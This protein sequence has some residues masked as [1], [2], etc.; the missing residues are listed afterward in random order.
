MNKYPRWL[1]LV[2]IAA[3]IGA[4]YLIWS[5]YAGSPAPKAPAAGEV[6][7]EPAVRN[8]MPSAPAAPSAPLPTLAE[9]DGPI[10]EAIG[11]AVPD[12]ALPQWL[13]PTDI[14]R[15]IV[16]SVDNLPRHRLASRL[17]P[18]KPAPDAPRINT[19]GGTLTWSSDNRA[20]YAPYMG[21]VKSADVGKLVGV[22]RHFY[23]L[24]QGAYE[25]LG[26]PSAYFNDRLVETIDDL[27]A[28]PDLSG[29]IL[30]TRPGV[31]YQYADPALEGRSAGQKF[32]M[33]MGPDNA[34]IVKA[35]LR[36]LRAAVAQAPASDPR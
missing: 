3:A 15:H 36:E 1:I 5:Y 35:K 30:L 17:R 29:P 12:S 19:S 24:F 32:L 8:P 16:A 26:Y 33:R 14:V 10:K 6:G 21:L 9:S 34:A 11:Q 28:A 18:L 4:I 25:Q 2:T 23:P 31:L 22:Y 7:H 20:R 13:I 27:L